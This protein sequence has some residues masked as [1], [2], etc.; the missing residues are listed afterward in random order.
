M[1]TIDKMLEALLAIP[2]KQLED[3]QGR[4]YEL[5]ATYQSR[6]D[7]YTTLVM[8]ESSK[9]DKLDPKK[10]ELFK[11]KKA[12]IENSIQA[13]EN[14]RSSITHPTARDPYVQRQIDE[15]LAKRITFNVF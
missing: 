6:L 12:E 14:N 10:L 5:L 3:K 2:L 4:E 1:E 13:I 11:A 8:E 7:S 9:G 15:I